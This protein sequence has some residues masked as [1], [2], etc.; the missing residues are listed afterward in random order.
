MYKS[1]A[2]DGRFI[3]NDWGVTPR[4]LLT[5]LGLPLNIKRSIFSN[6]IKMNFNILS[7]LS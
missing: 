2:I 3:S 5:G 6:S 1:A 7:G 4:A